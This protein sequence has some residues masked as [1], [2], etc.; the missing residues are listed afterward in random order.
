M[1]IDLAAVLGRD[2]VQELGLVGPQVGLR[3]APRELPVGARVGRVVRQLA[4]QQVPAGGE[5]E[6]RR[7]DWFTRQMIDM[8]APTNF[9]ATNPDALLKALETEG[10]SLV[11]GLE[12]LVRDI[13]ESGGEMIVS[14]MARSPISSSFLVRLE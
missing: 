4:D 1:I 13:E 10:D 11:R 12:N 6:R 3:R 2:R 7:V 8:L 9:L 5:V 14:L